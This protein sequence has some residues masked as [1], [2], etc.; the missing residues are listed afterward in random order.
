MTKVPIRVY[1][2]VTCINRFLDITKEVFD[3]IVESGLYDECE[4]ISIGVLG[5]EDGKNKLEQL[6]N[7]Y[8]KAKIVKHHADV[9]YFEF[10]TISKLKQDADTLPLFYAL[11]MHS[12]GVMT[13]PDKIDDIKFKDFWR[14]YMLHWMVSEWSQCYTALDLRDLDDHHSGYDLCGVRVVPA[15]KSI[16]GTTHI[17]GNYWW[18]SS[19]YIKSL[20]L[21]K[22]DTYYDGQNPYAGGHAPEVW[23]C[24][25]DPI[26]FMP[27]NMFQ[28]GFPY[29]KGSFKEYMEGLPN[30][31]KYIL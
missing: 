23:P 24:S 6:L 15:R 29:D 20:K 18:A 11:Y 19:D 13:T 1:Y 9:S 31:E 22:H 27:C 16:G 14:A 26:I 28:M 2:H 12:K 25:G 30:K 21:V 3:A 4:S 5:S 8:P 7:N 10:F 17:S